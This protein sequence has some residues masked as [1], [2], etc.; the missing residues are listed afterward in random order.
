MHKDYLR[1][2]RI[3]Y[4]AAQKVSDHLFDKKKTSIFYRKYEYEKD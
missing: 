4:T 1:K 3:L 2:L